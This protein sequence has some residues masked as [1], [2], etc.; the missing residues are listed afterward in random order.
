MKECSLNFVARIGLWTCLA[1]ESLACN[2]LLIP[3]TWRR[4]R[5]ATLTLVTISATAAGVWGGEAAGLIYGRQTL[6]TIF[7]CI[8]RVLH[9]FTDESGLE[10]TLLEIS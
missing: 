6:P 7:I 10:V 4:R 3:A 8:L 1:K 2:I 9:C 5:G